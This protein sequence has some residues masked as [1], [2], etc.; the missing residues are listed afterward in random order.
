MSGT[1][2]DASAVLALAFDE[3]GADIV[4]AALGS[5]AIS[6]VNLSEAGAKMIDK[7]FDPNQAIGWLMTLGLRILPFDSAHAERAARLRSDKTLK[8]LS[9]ADRACIAAA[10]TESA[11][12]LTTDRIWADLDLP[13]KV[14]LIR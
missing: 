3:P 2:L 13:C 5:A 10:S 14:E 8:R 6:A 9:F 1:L 7:G 12:A 11:S 4:A